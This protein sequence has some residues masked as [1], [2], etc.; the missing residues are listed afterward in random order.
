M[1][2]GSV[3]IDDVGRFRDFGF[4]C[5]CELNDGEE[6]DS[7]CDDASDGDE[8]ASSSTKKLEDEVAVAVTALVWR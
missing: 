1:C 4:G 2:R 8:D 6:D 3:G 7:S 5:F